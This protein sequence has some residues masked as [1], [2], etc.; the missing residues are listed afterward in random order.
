MADMAADAFEGSIPAD[1]A[2]LFD[3][4]RALG[5]CGEE[6]RALLPEMCA[7]DPAGTRQLLSEIAARPLWSR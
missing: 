6:D 7:M 2:R 3:R 4:C 5:R 1:V